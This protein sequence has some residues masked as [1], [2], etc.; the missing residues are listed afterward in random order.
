[1]NIIQILKK[2]HREVKK[3]FETA[4]ATPLGAEARR[5]AVL[6]KIT[7]A[8][9]MHTAAEEAVLY[10]PLREGG[11]TQ[12]AQGVTDDIYEA[13]EEHHLVRVLLAELAKTPA[14]SVQWLAKMTVLHEIV[15]HHVKE[16]E[17]VLFPEVRRRFNAAALTEMGKLFLKLK[18]GASKKPNEGRVMS[19]LLE[20]V[21]GKADS[22]EHRAGSTR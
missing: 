13:Y 9:S 15:E 20:R 21:N 7:E 8:L 5:S 4:E 6:K 16:E 1:M 3:L 22:R 18:K 14:E 11:S 19:S 10:Q 12:R 17:G 2:E